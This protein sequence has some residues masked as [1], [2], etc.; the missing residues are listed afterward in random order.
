MRTLPRAVLALLTI[1][2]CTEAPTEAPFTRAPTPLFA[3]GAKAQFS[4]AHL[5][6][7][8]QVDVATAGSPA[9]WQ[10]AG[11]QGDDRNRFG[12]AGG[13]PSDEYQGAFCGVAAFIFN[14]RP[15]ESGTLK[16]DPDSEY[17]TSMASSCGPARS[18]HFYLDG[19]GQPPTPIGA[20][21]NVDAIWSLAPGA[22]VLQ[23]LSFANQG[24]TTSCKLWFDDAYPPAS[25]ARITRLADVGAARQWRIESQGSH[26]ASCTTPDKRGRPVPTGVSHYLPF[27]VTVTEVPPPH[28]T[29]P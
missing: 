26:R 8:D 24:A 2:A 6:W 21:T 29:F 12:V 7:A 14:S 9:D 22:V 20:L 15:T 3:G 23:S 1:S 17:L 25:H 18:F 27:A 16:V 5:V 19:P 4:R 11:I 13:L 10:P 28:P